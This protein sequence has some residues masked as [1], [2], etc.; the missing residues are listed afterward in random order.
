[1]DQTLLGPVVKVSHVPSARL[2]AG[3]EDAGAGCCEL[4]A[5]VGV[6][7]RR[8]EQLRELGQA[9]SASTGGLDVATMSPRRC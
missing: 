5:A 9:L 3:G 8:S 6:G 2:V 4:I 7:D 1:V